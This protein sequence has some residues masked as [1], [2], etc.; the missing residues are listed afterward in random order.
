VLSSC[1]QRYLLHGLDRLTLLSCE[2]CI[3][4]IMT[5]YNVACAAVNRGLELMFCMSWSDV[6][7]R[8]FIGRHAMYIS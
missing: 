2:T 7:W 1:F 8:R 4:N 3:F 5:E 6:T